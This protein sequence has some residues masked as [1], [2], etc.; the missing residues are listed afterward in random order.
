M[1]AI[2]IRGAA[3]DGDYFSSLIE[4]AD[5]SYYV[6]VTFYED[7]ALSRPVR[8]T[9]GTVTITATEDDFNYGT[10]LNGVI[11]VTSEEYARPSLVFNGIKRFKASLSG[12]VGANNFIVRIT[13][14][15]AI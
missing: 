4:P 3:L 8:P 14:G 9:A 2:N 1:S 15:R 12:V 7:A 13:R 10:I 11:D 6:S 5:C